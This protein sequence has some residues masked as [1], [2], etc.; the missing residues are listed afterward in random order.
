MKANALE[1]EIISGFRQ[2]RLPSDRNFDLMLPP[3][4][5][6]RS[7]MHWTPVRIANMLARYL[8]PN[9][10][11]R[12]LDIGS[13]CGKFCIVG[14]LSTPGQFF[15]VEQKRPLHEAAVT[16]AERLKQDRAQFIHG[17]AFAQNWNDFSA[18][19]FYNPFGEVLFAPTSTDLLAAVA[20]PHQ[21]ELFV[22][23]TVQRLE[24]LPSGVRV[25]TYQGFGGHFPPSFRLMHSMD[26]GRGVIEV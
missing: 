26:I 21:F 2:G 4:I 25:A 20:L 3:G 13:G 22:G 16:L 7:Q 9:E 12:I 24:G 6:S 14:A 11:S 17:D 5:R 19:Y 23:S 18:L 10:H 15:G 1:E 8:A